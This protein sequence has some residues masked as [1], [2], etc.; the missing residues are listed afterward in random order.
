VLKFV[1]EIV[2]TMEVEM[3]KLAKRQENDRIELK[4]AQSTTDNA[5]AKSLEDWKASLTNIRLAVS[6]NPNTA[7]LPKPT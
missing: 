2:L 4:S 5:P 3:E 1:K 7:T 6:A